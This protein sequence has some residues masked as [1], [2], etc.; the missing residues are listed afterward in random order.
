MSLRSFSHCKSSSST[1]FDAKMTMFISTYALTPVS[2]KIN[3]IT[4]NTSYGND[5]N[6]GPGYIPFS[7]L[8]S[9]SPKEK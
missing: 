7:Q 4:P 5:F 3:W 6:Y 1:L 9:G 2:S 8:Q